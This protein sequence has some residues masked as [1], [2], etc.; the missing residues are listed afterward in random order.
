MTRLFGKDTTTLALETTVGRMYFVGAL[1][2]TS[3]DAVDVGVFRFLG[4]SKELLRTASSTS[5]I[6]GI[7]VAAFRSWPYPQALQ[8]RIF[9]AQQGFASSRDLCRLHFDIGS[10]FGRAVASTLAELV[11]VADD[12]APRPQAFHDLQFVVGTHG[13]T[14]WHEVVDGVVHSTLQIGEPSCIAAVLLETGFSRFSIVSDF[15]VA[16]VALGGQ[17]A[18]L[19][20]ELDVLL[21]RLLLQ[22]QLKKKEI[23]RL[24]RSLAAPSGA[25]AFQNIGGI[26]NVT[27]VSTAS[28]ERLSCFDSGPGNCLLDEVVTTMTD[29]AMSFDKDGALAEAGSC[30]KEWVTRTLTELHYFSRPPPKSTGRELFNR[31]FA[32]ACITQLE[33]H[34]CT[35]LTDVVCSV[36][37]LTVQSIVQGYVAYGPLAA[38]DLVVFNGGGT[39]NRYLMRRIQ[40]E[41]CR[42]LPPGRSRSLTI[43]TDDQVS[44]ALAFLR[45][46]PPLSVC[47]ESM[48]F[49][50]LAFLHCSG[51]PALEVS[52]TSGARQPCVLGKLQLWSQSQQAVSPACGGR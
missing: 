4:P 1:S 26:A 16:D 28:T 9:A 25:V 42:N 5:A 21:A 18:P 7:D 22:Q 38:L 12:G 32:S 48:L 50:Y 10:F 23:A 34:G 2:G 47:K 20:V 17:G 13:Q 24:D 29:G 46:S 43:L 37:E 30:C 6:G 33:A 35:R 49:A 39:R 52:K 27:F 14:I 45:S 31:E 44:D 11:A 3:A 36:A 51:Q 41:L 15:R 19:I 40:E 8:G